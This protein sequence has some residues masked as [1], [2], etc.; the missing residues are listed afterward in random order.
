MKTPALLDSAADIDTAWVQAVLAVAGHGTARIAHWQQAPIGH[1]KISDTTRLLI[2]YAEA[3]AEAPRSLICKFRPQSPQAHQFALAA[4]LYRGELNAYRTIGARSDCRIP[5]P[6]WVAGSEDNINL[7]LEDLSASTRAG[8]QIAG[9]DVTAAAATLN[10]IARLHGAFY[11]LDEARAP[12]WMVRM[13]DAG[14]MWMPIIVHGARCAQQRFGALLSPRYLTQFEAIPQLAPRF[15][16]ARSGQLCLTHGDLRVDNVLFEGEAARP[17]A[18]IIDWQNAGLRNPMFDAGYFLSGSIGVDD[19]LRHER[20]LLADYAAVLRD[21]APEYPVDSLIDDYRV[22]LLSGLLQS[23]AAV[24][25]LAGAPDTELPAETQ[26]FLLTLLG[27]NCA[28]VDDWD[29]LAALEA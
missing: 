2:D 1:G 21:T 15:F 13:A 17:R 10:E 5:K 9:C 14:R 27:R 7:V 29:S 25:F 20:A 6:Y 11:P 16:N 4:R 12:D 28:A 22:Q 18:V 19:R 24:G 8:D 23:L 3:P 26:T